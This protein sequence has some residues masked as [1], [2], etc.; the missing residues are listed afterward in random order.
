M[1]LALEEES[2]I[3]D[4]AARGHQ[5][6]AHI[7]NA[8]IESSVVDDMSR[9][10]AQARRQTADSRRRKARRAEMPIFDDVQAARR[11]DIYIRFMR[12]AHRTARC[13]G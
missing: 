8:V 5:E 7:V 6:G 4:R 1:F 13:V 10:Q 3:T 12:R 9:P 11:I 2:S